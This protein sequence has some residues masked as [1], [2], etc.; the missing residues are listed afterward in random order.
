MIGMIGGMIGGG[1]P[2]LG[3]A[4]ST[5]GRTIVRGHG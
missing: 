2:S 4:I 1:L 5:G 3:S